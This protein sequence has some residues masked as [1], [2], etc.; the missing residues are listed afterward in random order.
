M[1]PGVVRANDARPHYGSVAPAVV[2]VVRMADA[3]KPAALAPLLWV[4]FIATLGFSLV[5]PFL[6]FLVLDFGGNA[7]VYG[8]VGATYSATQLVGAPILGRWSD[9]VGRR[10]ILL[11]SQLGTLLAWL[12][13]LLAMLLPVTPLAELDPIWLG[14]FTLTMPLLLLVGARALD[15]LTGGN[16]AVANAYV[17]DVTSETQRSASFGRMA[18][19]QN[20]GFVVG[21][22]L[23]GVLG[24]SALGAMLPVLAA[25]AIS[26]VALGLIAWRLPESRPRDFVDGPRPDCVGKV[27]G[28]EQRDC[29]EVQGAARLGLRAMARIPGVALLLAAHFLIYLAFNFFYVAFPVH[30]AATLEWSVRD[31]GLFFSYLSVLMVLVQGPG[32]TWASRRASDRALVLVGGLLLGCSFLLFVPESAWWVVAGAALL[33]AGNG[34]MWP[35]LLSLLSKAAGS[36]AQGAVQGFAGS[37]SAVASILGLLVGGVFY[38]ILGSTVFVMSALVVAAAWGLGWLLPDAALAGDR[39]AAAEG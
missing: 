33:S 10:R 39:A 27:L 24:A 36:Q 12:L 26:T 32:L 8:L 1:G 19:A 34:L 35:A 17:A 20:L 28:Q 38:G 5:L 23:A 14:R 9:R 11:L 15:G 37:A 18:V 16:V 13:F 29:H 3:S 22:A 25:I 4:T 7:V 21:P 6:V 30:A 31:V 2:S